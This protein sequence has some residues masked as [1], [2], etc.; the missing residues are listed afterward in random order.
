MKPLLVAVL[1]TVPLPTL[2]LSQN[3][4][5][6]CAALMAPSKTPANAKAGHVT[7]LK[8][9]RKLL[10]LALDA[11]DF[12]T[13]TKVADR[14]YALQDSGADLSATDGAAAIGTGVDELLN[15]ALPVSGLVDSY[16]G[17]RGGNRQTRVAVLAACGKADASIGTIH[18]E[19]GVS[20]RKIRRIVKRRY[21]LRAN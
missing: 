12:A 21:D 7:A 17:W 1:L 2:A 8:R 19:T 4:D 11:G 18:A 10:R 3:V 20:A 6:M 9:Y 15:V 5:F 13:A 16:R 14:L